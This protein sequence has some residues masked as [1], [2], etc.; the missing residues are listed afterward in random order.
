MNDDS[1]KALSKVIRIDESEIRRHLD[2]MVRGTV[3]EMRNSLLDAEAEEMWNA[4][5]NERSPDRL[6]TRAG[7]YRRKLHTEAGEVEVQ[8]R[9]LGKQ[10][11]E[12]VFIARYR[13]AAVREFRP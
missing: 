12:T 10:A 11:F 4:Q 5:R 1:T 7:H 3:E 13:R 9:R 2:E 6:D 8:M